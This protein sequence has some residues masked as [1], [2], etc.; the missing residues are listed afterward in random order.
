M[1]SEA[2]KDNLTQ[3]FDSD[4]FKKEFLLDQKSL[5]KIKY[6]RLGEVAVIRGGKRI[7]IDCSFSQSGIPYIR[8][9]DVKYFV[10]RS[11]EFNATSPFLNWS[12]I[13]FETCF[14]C[15]KI[16][17]LIKEKFICQKEFHV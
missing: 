7:P 16:I 3:R 17:N 14:K 2:V 5:E 1:L 10:A 13:T 11:P 4:Y 9:E 15:D 8:A 6:A 12:K